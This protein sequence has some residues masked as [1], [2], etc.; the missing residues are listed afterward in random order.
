MKSCSCCV[1]FAIVINFVNQVFVFQFLIWKSKFIAL[2]KYAIQLIYIIFYG[3]SNYRL[4][5]QIFIDGGTTKNVAVEVLNLENINQFLYRFFLVNIQ[6]EPYSF[7]TA[8]YFLGIAINL[9]ILSVV[10]KKLFDKSYKINK[11]FL[12]IYFIA[13]FLNFIYVF[14][15][16]Y[17]DNFFRFNRIILFNQI[18]FPILFGIIISKIKYVTVFYFIFFSSFLISGSGIEKITSTQTFKG[19]NFENQLNNFGQKI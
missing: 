14:D 12:I 18:L 15:A 17:S 2:Y 13:Q 8:R 10:V 5:F 11:I 4:L 3:I 1:F 7:V 16:Y 6:G 19:L 9:Y